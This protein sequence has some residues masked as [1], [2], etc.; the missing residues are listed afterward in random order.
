MSRSSSNGQVGHFAMCVPP[1]RC[2]DLLQ[3]ANF[4]KLCSNGRDKVSG[5]LRPFNL[6]H[7]VGETARVLDV[8]V[9]QDG[10]LDRV[11]GLAQIGGRLLDRGWARGGKTEFEM[12][13]VV[14]KSTV[15]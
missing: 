7:D 9:L 13:L 14:I 3:L 6:H 1:L 12:L 8:A 2:E 5:P 10:R 4:R 15:L 11:P